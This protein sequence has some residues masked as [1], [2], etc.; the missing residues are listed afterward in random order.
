MLKLEFKVVVVLPPPDTE[1]DRHRDGDGEPAY[2]V[3][4]VQQLVQGA[5]EQG[6]RDAA[7]G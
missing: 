3:D 7:R 4:T 5:Y 1:T 6:K 2:T